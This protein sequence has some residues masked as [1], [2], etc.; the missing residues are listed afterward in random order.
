MNAVDAQLLEERFCKRSFNHRRHTWTDDHLHAL[1]DDFTC[2]GIWG[3][4]WSS[5]GK[6][7]AISTARPTAAYAS[8]ER[9][10]ARFKAMD[11]LLGDRPE[12]CVFVML[13]SVEAQLRIEGIG[14]VVL[15]YRPQA[16][17]RGVAR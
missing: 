16:V 7:S 3:P 17:T 15:P 1:G 8:E 13:A 6:R 12:G 2:P 10:A 4:A 5:V 11:R 14:G 9:E